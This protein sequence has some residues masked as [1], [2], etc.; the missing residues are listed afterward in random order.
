M[1]KKDEKDKG[2][3]EEQVVLGPGAAG[4]VSQPDLGTGPGEPQGVDDPE[5]KSLD[6]I[7]KESDS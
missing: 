4:D 1:A 2:N 6:E 7:E 3:Q 5:G